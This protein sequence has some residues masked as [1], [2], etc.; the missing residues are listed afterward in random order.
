MITCTVHEPPSPPPDRLDRAEEIMFVREG[1]SWRAA[2]FAPFW[3]LANRL[4]LPL[5]GYIVLIVLLDVA[6]TAAGVESKWIGLAIVALNL[7]I[8]FEAS[9]LKRWTLE[10]RGWNFLGPVTGVSRDDCERRFFDAWLQGEPFLEGER[11]TRPARSLA[12]SGN[13]SR[14]TEHAAPRLR[15]R[16]SRIWRR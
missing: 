4:W 13:T 9:S 16:L 8:G 6:L 12:G 14:L 3:M 10:R 1:F 2:L 7:A 11:L 5:I 15:D